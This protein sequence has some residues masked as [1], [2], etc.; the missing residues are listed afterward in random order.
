M[1]R[2]VAELDTLVMVEN[3]VGRL[4]LGANKYAA[5]DV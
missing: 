3:K 4:A 2:T 1:R 5:V